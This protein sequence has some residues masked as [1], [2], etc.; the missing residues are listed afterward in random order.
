MKKTFTI[1]GVFSMLS[2]YSQYGEL[3]NSSFESWSIDTAYTSPDNWSCSNADYGGIIQNTIDTS[4][5]IDGT[6]A[7]YMETVQFNQD[8]MFGYVMLGLPGQNGPG[9][10]IDY[11]AAVDSIVG[12]WKYQTMGNDSVTVLTQQK[13]GGV[14]AFMMK[15]VTGSQTTWQ[16]FSFPLPLT[17]GQDSIMVAFASGNAMAN[18]S[19]PGSWMMVDKV[20][21][22]S[23]NSYATNLPNYS[24]ENWTPATAENP[25]D[26]DS[27]NA[28]TAALGYPTLT[29]TTNAHTGSFAA[30][31]ST[32]FVPQFYDTVQGVLTKG[33]V[34][35]VLNGMGGIS[36]GANPT[37]FDG[38]Y[39]Y[40]PSGI[41]TARF[42]ILFYNN[43]SIVGGTYFEVTSTVTSYTA[44]NQSLVLSTTPDSLAVAIFA[45]RNPGSTLLLDDINLS[46]G[47]VSVTEQ[48]IQNFSIY[49]TVTNSTVTIRFD[50]Q[51][52]SDIDLFVYDMNGKLIGSKHFGATVGNNIITYD[53]TELPVGNY[54]IKTSGKLTN[55][56]GIVTKK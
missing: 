28:N 45:G 29:K 40:T 43:Q 27:F 30:Q 3:I 46:G 14:P 33:P 31:L 1:L 44:F 32:V 56:S 52:Q 9:D 37:S 53:F 20:Q 42:N 34:M 12:Y 26:W 22:K 15:K 21:L 10:G 24:F 4:D 50:S 25:D 48:N 39:Q 54:I 38:F 49:P 16:R 36:Y 18:F 11:T 35:N 5:A 47:N 51:S 41:D 55:Y 17:T 19:V 13:I 6:Q 2:A 23:G 7:I 8:T